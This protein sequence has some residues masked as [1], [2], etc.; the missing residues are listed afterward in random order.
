MV[1]ALLPHLPGKEKFPRSFPCSFP[2]E[3]SQLELDCV[4]TF[5]R[6]GGLG[7]E[8]VPWLR[9]LIVHC[10]NAGERDWVVG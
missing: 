3:S 6:K 5:C 7:G 1:L 2:F 10:L 4:T 8:S 9:P